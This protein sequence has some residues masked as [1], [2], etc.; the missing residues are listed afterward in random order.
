MDPAAPSVSKI[1]PVILFDGVCN[2]CNGWVQFLLEHDK[3]ATFR[4]SPLQSK[5]SQS[6]FKEQKL[7]A[8]YLESIVLVE[9]SDIYFSST[10]VLRTMKLLGGIYSL[11]YLMVIIPK[12]IREPVYHFIV[13]H[14][15]AWFGKRETCMVPAKEH[16]ARFID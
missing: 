16:L 5:F 1:H 11:L 7:P 14:R 3:R 10:A 9:G 8:N 15:Y 12:F 13:K 4:F 2:L 6:I